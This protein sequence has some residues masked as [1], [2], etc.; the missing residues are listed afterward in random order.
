VSRGRDEWL[1]RRAAAER[2][3]PAPVVSS[4]SVARL[5]WGGWHVRVRGQSLVPLGTAGSV[6]VGGV[7]LEEVRFTGSEVTGRLGSLPQTMD[8]TVDLGITRLPAVPLRVAPRPLLLPPDRAAWIVGQLRR[9]L[10]ER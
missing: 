10:G 2:L 6:E 1:A 5:V 9:L 8:V 7:R 4:A 3:R